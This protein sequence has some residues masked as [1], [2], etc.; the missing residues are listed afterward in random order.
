MTLAAEL[1]FFFLSFFFGQSGWC[2]CLPL[3]DM[4]VR[5]DAGAG[6]DDL[7]DGGIGR[8][9]AVGAYSSLRWRVEFGWWEVLEQPLQCSVVRKQTG[10]FVLLGQVLV[11]GVHEQRDER[12]VWVGHRA[13]QQRHHGE[14]RVVDSEIAAVGDVGY[15]DVWIE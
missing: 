3:E 5:S 4:V 15:L 2:L 8:S 9:L 13:L 7:N 11:D 12:C 1:V 6:I 10:D 14:N